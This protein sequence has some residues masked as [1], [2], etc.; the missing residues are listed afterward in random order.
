MTFNK[1]SKAY[2]SKLNAILTFLVKQGLLIEGGQL[3]VDYLS[4]W[5]GVDVLEASSYYFFNH[6]DIIIEYH[7]K[8]NEWSGS[9][10]EG[11]GRLVRAK[12][13]PRR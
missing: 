6:L 12:V 10:P 13:T 4:V 9:V 11:A 2:C 7:P 3:D 5:K 8:E 1:F